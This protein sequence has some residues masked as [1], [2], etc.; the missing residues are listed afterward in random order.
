MQLKF[1]YILDFEQSEE[2]IDF[3]KYVFFFF[4]RLL[5]PKISPEG[6]EYSKFIL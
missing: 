4:G 6:I 5:Y 1:Y 3:Y 2:C